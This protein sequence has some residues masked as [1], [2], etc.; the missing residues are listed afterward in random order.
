MPNVFF[1]CLETIKTSK[2]LFWGI[3]T[4]QSILFNMC[5]AFLAYWG[6]HMFLRNVIWLPQCAFCRFAL[7]IFLFADYIESSIWPKRQ[8][9]MVFLLSTMTLF[10][11]FI[12]LRNSLYG[13]KYVVRVTFVCGI[14]YEYQLKFIIHLCTS[15]M[16]RNFILLKL[17]V[18]LWMSAHHYM[19][20]LL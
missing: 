11:L 6:R 19:D 16:C 2:P 10:E 4:I 12:I 8:V 18:Q 17:I 3:Q 15:L 5:K 20:I 9:G 14:W 13:T 1:R 7:P